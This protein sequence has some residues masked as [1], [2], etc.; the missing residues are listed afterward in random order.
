M[1]TLRYPQWPW[2][3]RL[4]LSEVLTRSNGNQTANIVHQMLSE[5]IRLEANFPMALFG[6]LQLLPIR[7]KVTLW[8]SCSRTFFHICNLG[9]WDQDGRGES[10]WDDFGHYRGPLLEEDDKPE[11]FGKLMFAAKN[12]NLISDQ[13]PDCVK[14]KCDGNEDGCEVRMKTFLILKTSAMFL[15]G[16]QLWYRWWCLQVIWKLRARYKAPSRSKRWNVSIFAF[17]A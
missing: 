11:W 15:H 8:I 5:I 14:E 7:L 2:P 12:Y 9:A 1:T 13:D 6:V 16:Y 4:L 3:K 10:I 17:L